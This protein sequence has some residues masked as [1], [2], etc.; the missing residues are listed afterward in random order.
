M[1]EIMTAKAEEKGDDAMKFSQIDGLNKTYAH[2]LLFKEDSPTLIAVI[3]KL[4]QNSEKIKGYYFERFNKPLFK[5]LLGIRNREHIRAALDVFGVGFKEPRRSFGNLD[6]KKY[7]EMSLYANLLNTDL[8]TKYEQEMKDNAFMVNLIHELVINYY[9]ADGSL[10]VDEAT[11]KQ[12]LN[13]A[14]DNL[15][16]SLK[17][18]YYKGFEFIV[19]EE[20]EKQ[21]VN[22]NALE[23]LHIFTEEKRGELIAKA[24]K[25]YEQY[26]NLDR[27]LSAVASLYADAHWVDVGQALQVVATA[28]ANGGATSA[29][30]TYPVNG[31]RDI[32]TLCN[33]I[34]GE[35]VKI[36]EEGVVSEGVISE[37]EIN[38]GDM[39]KVSKVHTSGG[40]N[41]CLI[42]ALFTV[43]CNE[44]RILSN[45]KKNIVV[46]IFRKDFFANMNPIDE[47]TGKDLTESEYKNNITNIKTR[48]LTKN[49]L[50]EDS[51]AGVFCKHFKINLL[52]LFKAHGQTLSI[53]PKDGN[54]NGDYYMIYNEGNAHFSGVRFNGEFMMVRNTKEALMEQY[55]VATENNCKFHEYM[56]FNGNYIILRKNIDENKCQ[57]YV[58]WDMEEEGPKRVLPGNLIFNYPQTTLTEEQILDAILTQEDKKIYMQ[59]VSNN[60]PMYDILQKIMSSVF[61]NDLIS[62]S[63][64]SS[65]K[66]KYKTKKRGGRLHMKTHR[67][68]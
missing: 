20:E 47:I 5:T 17:S 42:H 24:E 59:R 28:H 2:Y 41:S 4:A 32:T 66:T 29:T 22:I 67:R 37:E 38:F 33:W 50:L 46:E 11:N 36:A 23:K 7:G 51:D 64:G 62:T 43:L 10:A 21:P 3:D 44:Y 54:E 1:T 63:G 6:I 39:F 65:K 53:T 16:T 56:C 55:N 27:N 19:K 8:V 40:G 9:P 18:G 61:T 49:M 25:H 13:D 57:S 26:S 14:R 60:A 34:K 12:I 35:G 58:V 45:H 68:K 31:P 15:R 30:G 48:S 52:L